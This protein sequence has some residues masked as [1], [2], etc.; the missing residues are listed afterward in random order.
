MAGI[1]HPEN[2]SGDA[3]L[4]IAQKGAVLEISHPAHALDFVRFFA[5]EVV[6]GEVLDGKVVAGSLS[7]HFSARSC[8]AFVARVLSIWGPGGSRSIVKQTARCGIC[9]RLHPCEVEAHRT[10]AR[11]TPEE[12][13]R[14]VLRR[15]DHKGFAPT[16]GLGKRPDSRVDR[17]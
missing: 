14:G 3:E 13:F 12:R 15:A 5:N 8:G 9:G 16:R 4:D 10:D 2:G 1:Q 17:E 7:H 6:T 11:L